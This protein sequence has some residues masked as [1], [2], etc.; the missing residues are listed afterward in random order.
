MVDHPVVHRFFC[1]TSYIGDYGKT[2]TPLK[3][4]KKEGGMDSTP[5]APCENG[6]F[7]IQPNHKSAMNRRIREGPSRG[8]KRK[9]AINF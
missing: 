9:N 3:P 8:D 2:F 4:H 1:I 5:Y 6:I 7:T